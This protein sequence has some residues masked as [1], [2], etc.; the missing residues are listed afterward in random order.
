MPTFGAETLIDFAGR[1]F[2]A[3]GA[4]QDVATL[5]ASSLVDS[6]LVGHDSHGVVRVVQYL[7]S[8]EQ[9]QL[10]PR[11]QPTVRQETSVIAL[12]DA[13]GG[14]GQVAAHKAMRMA[15]D[16]AKEHGLAAIGLV[17]CGH[18]GRMGEWVEM[19]AQEGLISLAFCNGG[20][21]RGIVAPFGGV[22]RVL[23]TNPIAAAIPVANREPIVLD[24][25][26]S[27][28]A[29]GKVR[30]AR[31][32]G[33]HIPEGWILDKDGN[34]STTPDDLY[35]GGVL[36][37]AAGHKGFGLSLLVEFMAGLLTTSGCP[38]LGMAPRN[39]V[40]FMVLNPEPF[41]PL[42]DFTA[43]GEALAAAVKAAKP[44]PGFDEVLLPGE[45]E[46]RTAA[47]RRTHGIHLDETSW[48]QLVEAGAARGVETPT[49][50]D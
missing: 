49:I 7:S 10:D 22:A 48:A 36:L 8:I 37:P 21:G 41:R 28:V 3:A 30:I 39:G 18:V 47:H 11:A 24:F 19:A 14:F 9:G 42:A 33:K 6:N 46:S 15:I 43:E 45:P 29:E 13:H 38:A 23:G 2:Q 40:L 5:V 16:K 26:T 25:A 27:A 17:D 4:P 32:S 31:N 12:I 20:G 50:Y 1:I 35:D 44:A 34:P